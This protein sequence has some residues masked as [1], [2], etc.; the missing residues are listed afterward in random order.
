MPVRRVNVRWAALWALSGLVCGSSTTLAYTVK[1]TEGGAIVRWH[2]PAI[3]LRIDESVDRFFDG[4]AARAIIGAA[5]QAWAD[6]E[7]V[8]ELLINEGDPGPV[9][10]KSG[11]ASNGIYL[12]EDWTLAES[13]LAVT[14]A[15]YE[16]RTGKMV[17]TDILIN[18]NHPFGQ[19]PDGP[20]QV[21]DAYD[22]P[23]VMAHEMGHV[24]GLGES[25]EE[26]M[27]TMWP[28]IS[29]GETHQR[30]ID[31]DDLIGAADAYS[32][33]TL[34]ETSAGAGCVGNSVSVRRGSFP[35]GGAL[36]VLA[37]LLWMLCFRP[38]VRSRRVG[39]ALCAGVLLFGAPYRPEG[40]EGAEPNE[41]VE[42]ARTLAL[43]HVAQSERTAGL[44][45]AARNS[46]PKVRM[47]AAAVLER[48]GYREDRALAGK[49][50]QD[51]DPE[52]RRVGRAALGRLHSA[53][54]LARL[55]GDRPEAKARIAG[56][57]R[58]A[59]KIARG[60]LTGRG[61]RERDG[62]I[63]SHYTLVTDDGQEEELAI[64]GG[65]LD[66]FTQVVSEQDPPTE[67][68]SVVVSF[69]ERGANGWAHYREGV[70]Y[71]G[72]LGEGPGIEWRP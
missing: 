7:N 69:R 56:L 47:A 3:T 1:E 61:A 43:R 41:R 42:V 45:K 26:R 2:R 22:L 34:S 31:E 23:G 46:S 17:D 24:L 67:G 27:A 63:W 64:P 51:R 12:I 5:A 70:A 39:Q 9:G 57:M 71:G 28:N 53:P 62:L 6:I 60:T 52:V 44:V 37:V 11:S 55:A 20:A 35:T 15:T 16:S 59:H 33:A 19:M 13:S 32:G 29:R 72:W 66:G 21:R 36:I 58:N 49:L 14:V 4:L 10:F 18:A 40:S 38:Q 65:T 68:D 54:P 50:A 8:P 30:D 48:A 25:Y